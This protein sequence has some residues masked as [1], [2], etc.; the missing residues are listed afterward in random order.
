MKIPKSKRRA[1]VVV[2]IPNKKLERETRGC[3]L[4]IVKEMAISNVRPEIAPR[5]GSQ[6]KNMNVNQRNEKDDWNRQC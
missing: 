1:T 2:R 6:T 4:D 3:A 5:A